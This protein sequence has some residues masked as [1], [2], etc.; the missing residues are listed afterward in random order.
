MLEDYHDKGYSPIP[1]MPGEKIPG[2]YHRG[3]WRPLSGWSR[4]CDAPPAKMQINAWGLWPTDGICIALGNG[5]VAIDID[6]D[7]KDIQNIITS[8][9][10][11]SPVKKKGQ[12]GYTAFYSGNKTPPKKWKFLDGDNRGGVVVELLGQGRQTVLPPTIHP[13]TNKP[14]IWIT[15]DE[16]TD[17]TPDELPLLP[18]DFTE[19]LSAALEPL[20]IGLTLVEDKESLEEYAGPS[21]FHSVNEQAMNNIGL[22]FPKLNLPNTV[23]LV[24]GTWEAIPIWRNSSTGRATELRASN[25]KLTPGKGGYDFGEGRGYSPIDIVVKALGVTVHNAMSWLEENL[26]TTAVNIN[27]E[28]LRPNKGLGT[29]NLI[30]A[31]WAEFRK[32]FPQDPQEFPVEEIKDRLDGV[33]SETVK[34]FEDASVRRW[35]EGSIVAA[36]ASL[37]VIMGRVYRT[38]S[39]MRSNLYMVMTAKSG[40]GK[41]CLI[42]PTQQLFQ[43]AGLSKELG[44]EDVKSD[45]GLVRMLER[46]PRSLLILDELGNMLSRSTHKGAGAHLAGIVAKMTFLYTKSGGYFTGSAYAGEDPVTIANPHLGIL[47]LS[48]PEQFWDAF[49]SRESADGALARYMVISAGADRPKHQN[50]DHSRLY[51]LA[52]KLARCSLGPIDAPEMKDISTPPETLTTEFTPD[53]MNNWLK[54]VDDA[55]KWGA[56]AESIEAKAA[57]ALIARIAENAMKIAMINAIGRDPNKPIIGVSDV[58]LG[59][60]FS[61]ANAQSMVAIASTFISDNQFEKDV[62]DVLRFIRGGGEKGRSRSEITRKF[63][64]IPKRTQDDILDNLSTEDAGITIRQQKTSGRPASRYFGAN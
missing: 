16:L 15:P 21:G 23:R 50:P 51:L 10:P 39:N 32:D 64:R 18:D 52:P 60:I 62:N 38:P 24:S 36:F 28:S 17:F 6:T 48:T 30:D 33:A 41:S 44:P 63:R 13:D 49:S 54:L 26:N 11:P 37:G 14:Y 9:A 46:H 34:Y 42:E 27:I 35:Q 7:D 1:V 55:N 43:Q 20:G 3:E 5:V 25:L 59:R 29:P 4:Y 45:T 31:E 58:E 8:I 2:E 12:K 40:W 47:G 56:L 22:W 53:A 61:K 19:R 57:P